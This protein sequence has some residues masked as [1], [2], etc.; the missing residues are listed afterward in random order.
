MNNMKY[1]LFFIMSFFVKK[2]I[3]AKNTKY[4]L[5]EE[6]KKESVKPIIKYELNTS[7]IKLDLYPF[8][9]T[10]KHLYKN[11]IVDRYWINEPFHSKFVEILYAINSCQLWIK[12]PKTKEIIVNIRGINEQEFQARSLKALNLNEIIRNSIFEMSDIVQSVLSKKQTQTLLLTMMIY[13]LSK[14]ENLDEMLPRI[15]T[16]TSSKDETVSS[17]VNLFFNDCKEDINQKII[18]NNN[19]NISLIKDV[20]KKVIYSANEYSMTLTAQDTHSNIHKELQQ[21]PEK[22]LM[23]INSY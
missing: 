11:I 20:Y 7:P 13:I 17:I 19:C 5:R 1:L 22:R 18:P 8:S 3:K 12:S 9:Y 15:N 16:G 2:E 6:V 10:F 23:K 4:D 21:I 14:A